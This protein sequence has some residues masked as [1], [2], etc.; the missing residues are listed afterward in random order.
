MLAPDTYWRLSRALGG[1]DKKDFAIYLTLSTAVEKLRMGIDD[2]CGFNRWS[3]LGDFM[4][5]DESNLPS[6]SGLVQNIRYR[7]KYSSP[8]L[9]N[10]VP[11]DAFSKFAKRVMIN[12]NFRPIK[13]G[14][15]LNFDHSEYTEV[16]TKIDQSMVELKSINMR[17]YDFV[18]SSTSTIVLRKNSLPAF[19]S[20]S[21]NA[22]VGQTVFLNP[23]LRE[24]D[25]AIVAEALV[26]EAIH[27]ILIRSEVFAPFL[28]DV[29]NELP[30][31]RS[32]WSGREL[33]LHSLIGACFVW[34]G[35]LCFW[36]EVSIKD[37]LRSPRRA[38]LIER[39]QRGFYDHA[40]VASVKPW[41]NLI[42][43][44]IYQELLLVAEKSSDLLVL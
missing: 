4:D 6:F 12:A 26:H 2:L 35:L 23:H 14:E 41:R 21:S 31:I 29:T 5:G 42:N 9:C 37:A 30:T 16:L 43:P 8:L 39:A 28:V 36:Q 40:F 44:E 1:T 10:Q 22:F 34:F 24:I 11:I 18:L 20:S 7:R 33:G 17:L 32:P 38:W 25:C 27:H 19:L 3:A 13:Y 15:P